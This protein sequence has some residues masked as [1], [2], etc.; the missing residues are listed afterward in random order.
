MR[1][2]EIKNP[3]LSTIQHFVNENMQKFISV[4]GEQ[5]SVLQKLNLRNV[6]T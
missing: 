1:E 2:Q 3:D 6:I 5:Y 4:N